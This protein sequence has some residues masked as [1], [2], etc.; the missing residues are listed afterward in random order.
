V[1]ATSIEPTI[2]GYDKGL[3]LQI[4][5]SRVHAYLYELVVLDDS[6]IRS[7]A[8]FKGQEI[9]EP[10]LGATTEIF[11]N[12]MLAGAGLRRGDY[13]FVP[14]GVGAQAMTALVTHKVAGFT[15]TSMDR[16]QAES[17]SHL[18]FRSFR[19]PILVDIPNSGFAASPATI[20]AKGDVLKRF[21]RAIVKAAIL[22][23][24]NPQA[25]AR[26]ALMGERSQP[27]TPDALSAQAAQFVALQNVLAAADPSSPRIGYTPPGG[28][29]IYDRFFYNAGLTSTLVPA[30]AIVTNQF[31]AYANDFDR[32]AWIAE[33][34]KMR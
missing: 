20:A 11:A 6:P 4:F 2:Q 31:I 28:M 34:R 9:G 15:I 25:A 10:N 21:T 8:D 16:V 14:V 23:R 33:A 32:N 19:D 7:L 26:L 3:R 13:S 12:D 30:D 29:A 22:M 27:L 1:C 18:K 17:V 5:F 24:V